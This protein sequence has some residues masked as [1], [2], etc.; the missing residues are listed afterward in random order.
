VPRSAI[1]PSCGRRILGAIVAAQAYWTT[2][3][4]A[5][6]IR[7][8]A[9]GVPATIVVTGQKPTAD[10]EVKKQVETALHSNPYFYDGQ[11]T[12]TV[13]DG[14]VHLQGVVFDDWDLRVARR[15][16]KKIA[17]AKR[18]VNELEICSC[19]GGGGA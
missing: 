16:S 12:V 3:V 13:K 1:R 4:T 6:E 2:P 8:P 18:V 9:T 5:D 10:E 7:P 14:V 17:G 15:I 19:D 11:V